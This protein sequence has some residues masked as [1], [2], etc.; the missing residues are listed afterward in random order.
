MFIPSHMIA[1]HLDSVNNIQVIRTETFRENLRPQSYWAPP[2]L[3]PKLQ[4]IKISQAHVE[5]C[6]LHF[7]AQEKTQKLAKLLAPTR[8]RSKYSDSKE[9]SVACHNLR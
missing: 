4:Q 2:T 8:H 1:F 6:Y 5:A 3:N 9:F 7:I